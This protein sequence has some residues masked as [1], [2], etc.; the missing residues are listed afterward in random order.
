MQ[1]PVVGMAVQTLRMDCVADRS[2]TILHTFHQHLR[3]AQ[4]MMRVL[5]LA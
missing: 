1:T 5:S 2:A 3:L 4:G